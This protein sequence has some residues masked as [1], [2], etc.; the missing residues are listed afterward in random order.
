MQCKPENDGMCLQLLAKLAK[1]F[2]AGAQADV[3]SRSGSRLR[4]SHQSGCAL[5]R[6]D[7]QAHAQ[8]HVHTYPFRIH[9][10]ECEV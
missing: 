10:L 4:N 1:V 2:L 3:H 6:M 9:A 5:V 8:T 7:A